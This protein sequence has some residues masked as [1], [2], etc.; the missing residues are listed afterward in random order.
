[1]NAESPPKWARRAVA[2]LHTR[3]EILGT[4]AGAAL[5]LSTVMLSAINAIS[6]QQAIAMALPA[7]VTTVG[8]LIYMLVRDS[9]TAWQRGFQQGCQAGIPC[10]LRGLDAD[11]AAVPRRDDV[12]DD[13]RLASQ[14]PRAGLRQVR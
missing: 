14:L 2:W 13:A 9:R 11:A 4:Y 1:M 12:P 3:P 5:G 7:T 6:A 10:R 8:G